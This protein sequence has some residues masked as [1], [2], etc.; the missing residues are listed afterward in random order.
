[1][2]DT[3][4]GRWVTAIDYTAYEPMAERALARIVAEAA[5]QF[6]TTEGAPRIV[7]EHR[8]G[9]LVVGEASVAVAVGHGWRAPAMDA[10]RYVVEELKRR[11]PI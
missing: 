10:L 2:R 4:G 8:V 11:V 1:M 3:N 9:T 6:G 7:V 5:D